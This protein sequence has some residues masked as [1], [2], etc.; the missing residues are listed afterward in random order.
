MTFD[1]KLV[2]RALDHIIT[3]HLFPGAI[4]HAEKVLPRIKQESE[5]MRP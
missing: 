3:A 2:L 1:S 5:M 4:K